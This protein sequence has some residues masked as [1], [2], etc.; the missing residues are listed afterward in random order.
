[1]DRILKGLLPPV[2]LTTQ[3]SGILPPANGGTG[4]SNA[5]TLTNASNTTITGGGTLALAGFTLTVPATGTA[6]L[7]GTGW[8]C[9]SPSAGGIYSDAVYV[10][11]QSSPL[12]GASWHTI[13]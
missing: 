12:S 6:A 7:L 5:G 2:S 9:A 10:K 1:M 8:H 4:V 13:G 11:R 3:V